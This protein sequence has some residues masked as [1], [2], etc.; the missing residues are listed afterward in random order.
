MFINLT[1]QTYLYIGVFSIVTLVI[2]IVIYLASFGLATQLGDSEKR[3]SYE[4]GFDPFED[5]RIQFDVHFYLVAILFIVFDLEA[6]FVFPWAL[7][8]MHIGDAGFWSMMDFLGELLI[9]YAYV[10][11]MGALEV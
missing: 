9:G 8:L 4:C 5:S 7:N 3:S 2:G 6:A 11:F 10:W 1:A